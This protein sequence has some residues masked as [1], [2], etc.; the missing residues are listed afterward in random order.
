MSDE[1]GVLSR[2]SILV[3]LAL[4]M[5]AITTIGVGGIAASGIVA[6]RAQG[7]GSA[8][9]VAG[10]LRKQSHRMGS[11]ALA[12]VMNGAA[13]H[14]PLLVAMTQ[15]EASPWRMPPCKTPCADSRTAISPPPTRSWIAPGKPD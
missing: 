13:S 5:I 15:F 4:A 11:Q 2:H 1:R 12:D 8:I 10:S 14:G 3:G 9:N 7:S 6:E